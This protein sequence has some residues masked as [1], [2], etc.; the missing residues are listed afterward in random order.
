MKSKILE[1]DFEYFDA[2]NGIWITGGVLP[3][4]YRYFR[5][6]LC[7]RLFSSVFFFSFFTILVTISIAIFWIM[8]VSIRVDQS[9]NIF[10]F[11]LSVKWSV[12]YCACDSSIAKIM[13]STNCGLIGMSVY[14]EGSR[15]TQVIHRDPLHTQ[16]IYISTACRHK[17]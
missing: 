1:V 5:C 8:R 6:C 3:H 14:S 17:T 16:T 4:Q 7:P 12:Y 2:S 9:N 10:V 13:L 15:C 11:P